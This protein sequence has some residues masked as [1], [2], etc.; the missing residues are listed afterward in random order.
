[1]TRTPYTLKCVKIARKIAV[2]GRDQSSFS[3]AGE[4]G[5]ILI[6]K[7]KEKNVA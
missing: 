4:D 2:T 1:M 3:P 7:K 6:L 5:C